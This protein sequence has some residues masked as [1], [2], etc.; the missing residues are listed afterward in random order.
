MNAPTAAEIETLRGAIRTAL[1]DGDFQRVRALAGIL[2]EAAPNGGPDLRDI[3]AS[4]H[5]GD[6]VPFNNAPLKD[7]V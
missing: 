4:G 3:V 6:G 7:G 2:L 1:D 5:F